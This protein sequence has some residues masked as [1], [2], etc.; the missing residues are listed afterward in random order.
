MGWDICGISH[1]IEDPI[2]LHDDQNTDHDMKL[3]ICIIPCREYVRATA[4]FDLQS[5]HDLTS[6]P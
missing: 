3:S 5:Q 1:P 2:P 6:H 4:M